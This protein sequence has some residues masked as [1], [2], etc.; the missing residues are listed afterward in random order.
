MRIKIIPNPKKPW[1]KEL[2]PEVSKE[3][4]GEHEIVRS[5]ADATI[6]IGGDGTILY[7]GYKGLLEGSILGI[8]STHSYI[9]QVNNQFWKED[10]RRIL[11]STRR[12]KVMTLE[13]E[14]GGERY[15]AI[16][17]FVVHAAN[18]RVVDLSVSSTGTRWV[19]EGDGIIVSSS[20]GSAAYAYSAGGKKLKPEERRISLVPICPYKREFTP[21]IVGEDEAIEIRAG[22][23]CAFIVDGIFVRQLKKDEVLR[24]K[25]GRDI[26]FFQGV[27]RN[28]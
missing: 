12:M 22:D 21:V 18:Y 14:I 28:G 27:G 13:A 20:L 23:N 3:L 16:N 5:G 15:P 26:E 2:A 7:A 9:C 10:L 11:E 4:R 8:G 25:K 17:D 19:Y 6:C 24:I 1:A